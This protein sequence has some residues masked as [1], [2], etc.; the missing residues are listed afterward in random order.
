[1]SNND[2]PK[3]KQNLLTALVFH[4][5][6]CR[7]GPQNIREG[8]DVYLLIP[9][10]FS[11]KI[12]ERRQNATEL[13]AHHLHGLEERGLVFLQMLLCQN[14]STLRAL[15]GGFCLHSRRLLDLDSEAMWTLDS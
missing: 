13:L 11:Q 12:S 14:P 15:A 3:I 8:L 1:M 9:V 10:Q 6:L 4:E 5:L 7:H 2:S